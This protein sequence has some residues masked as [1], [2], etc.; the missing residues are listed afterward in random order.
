MGQRGQK[1]NTKKPCLQSL[2]RSYPYK[3]LGSNPVHDSCGQWACGQ[4][5]GSWK[6]IYKMGDQ[7]ER[8]V[9]KEACD[10]VPWRVTQTV[11]QS[12]MT[13]ATLCSVGED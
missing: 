9:T 8:I 1:P 3:V 4:L 7:L 2:G 12:F 10:A 13:R 11:C 5:Q 6:Q